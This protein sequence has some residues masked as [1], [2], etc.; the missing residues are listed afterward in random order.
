M[1]RAG[2]LENPGQLEALRDRT[3]IGRVGVPEDVAYWYAVL[4]SD[5]AK[6]VVGIEINVSGGQL[7]T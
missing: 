5:H 2:W 1:T 4:A 7:F 6:H 3:P